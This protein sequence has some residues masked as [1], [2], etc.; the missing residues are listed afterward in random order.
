MNGKNHLL[1]NIF[2]GI[3]FWIIVWLIP[4]LSFDATINDIPSLIFAFI[5][6]F[7][8]CDIDQHLKKVKPLEFIQH[9][10]LYTHNIIPAAL[11][12]IFWNQAAT[13][14]FCFFVMLHL[15]ADAW[16]DKKKWTGYWCIA[17]NKIDRMSGKQSYI[18]LTGNIIGGMIVVVMMLIW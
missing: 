15:L 11:L 4:Q 9:R 3:P 6:A 7:A 8:W 13:I 16:K 1:V 5:S 12:A 17:Y 18:W 10:S 14:V 2:F